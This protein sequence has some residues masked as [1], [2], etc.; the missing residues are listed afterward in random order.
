MNSRLKSVVVICCLLFPLFMS[1]Q[2]LNNFLAVDTLT[3]KYY[4]AEDWDKLIN[5][6]DKAINDGIDY[7]YLRMRM[8]IASYEKRKY[9]NSLLVKDLLDRINC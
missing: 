2:Q 7:Y 1:G 3:Y 6:G 9:T 4:L 5:A 8:G